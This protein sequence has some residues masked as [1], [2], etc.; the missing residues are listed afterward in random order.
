MMKT[1]ESNRKKKSV[2][3]LHSFCVTAVG[4][5]KIFFFICLWHGQSNQGLQMFFGITTRGVGAT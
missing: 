4:I 5:N 3:I 1:K 2:R